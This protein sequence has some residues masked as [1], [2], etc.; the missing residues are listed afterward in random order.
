M[1]ENLHFAVRGSDGFGIFRGITHISKIYDKFVDSKSH[2]CR[3]FQ[4]S[5]TGQ[6]FC[7]CDGVK[8][9]LIEVSTGRIIFDVDLPRTQQILFSP[10]DRVLATY[11]PYVTYIA[12]TV[13]NQGQPAPNLRLWSLPDGEHITTLIAQK[14]NSWHIQWT[15]D[16]IYLVRLVGSEIFIHKYNCFD[17]YESKLLVPKTESCSLSHGMEPHHIAVYVPTQGGNPASVQLRRLDHKFTI[18]STKT[19]FQCDKVSLLWSCKGSAV[20]VMAML[21]VDKSNMSYYGKQNLYLMAVNGDS[22]AVPLNKLGPVH[23]AKWSP[24]GKQFAVCYGFMPA[25]IEV[26]NTTLL[27]WAPDGQHVMTATTAPRLRID[28]CFR[29]WHYNGNLVYEKRYDHP[30][31]LWQVQWRPVPNNIYHSFSIVAS[32]TNVETDTNSA[33]EDRSSSLKHPVTKLV[34]V[35]TV[36]KN[37]AYVPPHL[38][39]GSTKG[40]L[41]VATTVPNSGDPA[42]EKKKMMRRLRR[43][44]VHI[45]ELKKRKESG[46]ILEAN[47][48]T[49]IEKEDEIVGELEKLKIRDLRLH[50]RQSRRVSNGREEQPST[51]NEFFAMKNSLEKLTT[52]VQTLSME[53]VE[54]ER[55]AQ[56]RYRNLVEE[57]VNLQK[58]VDKMNSKIAEVCKKIG[59]LYA[60]E[61]VEEQQPVENGKK[62]MKRLSA[63]SRTITNISSVN[64]DDEGK[65]AES[66]GMGDTAFNDGINRSRKRRAAANKREGDYANMLKQDI[67]I[68]VS[69]NT[70]KLRD[71][72]VRLMKKETVESDNSAY[73][74]KEGCEVSPWKFYK[75]IKIIPR[76]TDLPKPVVARKGVGRSVHFT[77]EWKQYARA[78][79]PVDPSRYWNLP[80]SEYDRLIPDSDLKIFASHGNKIEKDHLIRSMYDWFRSQHRIAQLRVVLS[81]CDSAL[82]VTEL[83]GIYVKEMKKRNWPIYGK[84]LRK[85]EVSLAKQQ[86]LEDFIDTTLDIM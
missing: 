74:M 15:D 7:Y 83:W 13:E 25:R 41:K 68:N 46:E 55:R 69:G 60:E 27:E 76:R 75:H 24:T 18:V 79:F 81:E 1:S 4:F 57:N 51:S 33:L 29:I 30:L 36:G 12:K 54:F 31:E 52:E 9:V 56:D 82:D 86:I 71:K 44:L 11:E 73:Y 50:V 59:E 70:S 14:Q 85:G 42:A 39:K 80:Q 67:S 84:S 38:R 19:L 5:N 21:D 3:V 63:E 26:P 34:T 10:K 61:T 53:I 65:S 64:I 40:A 17:K 23:C 43:K 35:G 62:M 37:S 45:N 22:C 49:K 58:E 47:Q 20:I 77:E 48:L 28:N 6:Y 8:T 16:E 66:N 72:K 32:K 78:V 2:S